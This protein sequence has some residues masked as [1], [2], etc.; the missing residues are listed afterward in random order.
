MCAVMNGVSDLNL[1]LAVHSA[2]AMPSL[3]I[4]AQDRSDRLDQALKEFVKCIG[5]ANIVLHLDHADLTN[6]S[7]M[8]LVN[9]YKVS[10]VELL[11]ALDTQ[12]MTTKQEFDHVMLNPVYASGLK[13]VQSTSK[14][15]IRILSPSQSSNVAGYAL[16]GN[17]AAGFGGKL[18]VSD[19]FDQQIQNTPHMPLIPYGG[20]GTPNDVADYMRRGAAGVAVGTLFAAT[21]ESCIADSTK[22]Q[23]VMASAGS[24]TKFDTSQQALVLGNVAHDN[25]PNRQA[26]LNQGLAGQGGLV[27]AG[28]AIDYVTEIRTVQQVVDYLTSEINDA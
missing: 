12:G 20:I 17:N 3:M 19:L 22:Q 2:G 5:N 8:K 18:S 15:I 21:K 4:L 1:A 25:T 14:T 16:K 26:S 10:H 28:P 9:Q 7:I 6:L 24:L 27:Y 11:G 23:M 13:F